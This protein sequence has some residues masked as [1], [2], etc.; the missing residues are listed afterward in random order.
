MSRMTA[1]VGEVT[2]PTTSGRTGRGRLRAASNSPSAASALRRSSS[3]AMSA[4]MPAG[5][6]RSTTIWYFDRPG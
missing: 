5:S 4:P 6:M 1:P 3:S 2:T